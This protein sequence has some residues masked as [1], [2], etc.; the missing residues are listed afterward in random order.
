MKKGC[1]IVDG[2][3]S[4]GGQ[5][6]NILWTL[7][8]CE[9]FFLLTLKILENFDKHYKK[10]KKNSLYCGEQNKPEKFWNPEKFPLFYKK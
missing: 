8:R 1:S 3:V 5:S 9:V 4:R 2:S 7:V 6:C 10:G